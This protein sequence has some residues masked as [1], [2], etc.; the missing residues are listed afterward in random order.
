MAEERAWGG[1]TERFVR[2]SARHLIVAPHVLQG[3]ALDPNDVADR[4]SAAY[5]IAV[6][7][8]AVSEVGAIAG[9][10]APGRGLPT[11]TVDTVIGFTIAG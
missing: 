1:I 7:A 10:V 3:V 5:L 4:L 6:N 2:R 9:G 11:L 8:R